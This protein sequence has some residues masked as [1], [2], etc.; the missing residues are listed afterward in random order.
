LIE[1]YFKGANKRVVLDLQGL[2]HGY[3]L[4]VEFMAS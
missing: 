2:K 4:L 3:L 1:R